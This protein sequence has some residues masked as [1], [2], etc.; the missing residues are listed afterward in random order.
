MELE[1][2]LVNDN[3]KTLMPIELLDQVINRQHNRKKSRIMKE[4]NVD[5]LNCS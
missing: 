4:G 2:N 5:F 3:D 1:V